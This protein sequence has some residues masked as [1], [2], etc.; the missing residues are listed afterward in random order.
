MAYMLGCTR[1]DPSL[2]LFFASQG[3][4]HT[5]LSDSLTYAA[6]AHPSTSSNPQI[7]LPDLILA[8]QSN[9]SHSLIQTP[10]KSTLLSLASTLNATPLPPISDRFGLRLPPREHC[11]TNVNF[12]IVPDELEDE[13]EDEEDEMDVSG[14]ADANGR[15]GSQTEADRQDGATAGASQGGGGNGPGVGEEDAADITM[16]SAQTPAS[17]AGAAQTEEERRG[18]KRSLDE[19]EDYD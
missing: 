15:A 1:T 7:S 10:A 12:R 19:D 14:A 16:A 3:Y 5:I 9:L 6:H 17:E 8:I 11:L 13:D 2:A 18:V 4:I